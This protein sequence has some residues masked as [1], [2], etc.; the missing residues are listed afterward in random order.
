MKQIK[1]DNT[2]YNII[3]IYGKKQDLNWDLRDSLAITFTLEEYNKI[4]T[5]LK[6]GVQWSFLYQKNQDSLELT[7]DDKSEY[8]V[9]GDIIIHNNNTV[10]VKMGKPT[11]EE[12]L[13]I[14]EEALKQ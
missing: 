10:T 3:R 5:V 11:A 4:K 8:S 6:N 14:L 2:L 9:L 1:I 12:K 7:E 13:A